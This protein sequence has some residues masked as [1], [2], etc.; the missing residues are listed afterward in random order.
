MK[1]IFLV[2][3]M[4]SVLLGAPKTTVAEFEKISTLREYPATVYS[5]DETMIATRVM[6]YI[7]S[8]KVEEG[9]RV[10]KGDLLFEVDPSDIES[11][12]AQAEAGYISA[13]GMYLD[14]LRDY[15]RFEELFNKGVVPERDFE[16]MKLNLEL[17]EQGLKMAEAG[18]NQAKAQSKY[19]S[20]KSPIDGVVV[21]KRAKVAEMAAPGHPVLILSSTENLRARAMVQE[22]EIGQIKSG[23]KA[24]VFVASIG[25][26]L[27]TTVYSVV[28]SGDAAT[29]SYEIRLDLPKTDG[30]LPGMYAKVQIRSALRDAVT[31]PIS[32][33][34]NRG[35]IAGVFVLDGNT[36]RFLP[37]TVGE[38]LGGK[39]EVSGVLP[40]S[41][42][43]E[44]PS[45]GI[46]DGKQVE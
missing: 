4:A 10:K 19:A 2:V 22:S 24:E 3:G 18:L 20:V 23:Q 40:N 27:S 36:A 42:V 15:E 9:D 35:G 17:R 26:L 12:Q 30:L 38:K 13:K 11:M 45:V 28:P 14:A 46:Q 7:K 39:V 34:T 44:H 8:I 21:A 16:K 1:K 33:L 29:H 43:I 37:V 32:A 41:F 5:Y 6:G 31:V 25:K